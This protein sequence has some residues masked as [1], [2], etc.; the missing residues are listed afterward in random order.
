[1]TFKFLVLQACMQHC[2]LW[3]MVLIC[4]WLQQMTLRITATHVPLLF[5]AAG[6]Y[7]AL[8]AAGKKADLSLIVADEPAVAGGCFTKNVMCAAP[9]L[10]CK[11]VLAR[12]KKIKAVSGSSSDSFSCSQQV[13]PDR[14]DN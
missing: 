4:C 1:M 13:K 3:K 14:Y 7:A 2:R 12:K 6:V 10:Y 8:R 11:D 9:V 5:V